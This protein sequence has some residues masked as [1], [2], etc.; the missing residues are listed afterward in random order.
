MLCPPEVGHYFVDNDGTYVPKTSN[1]RMICKR[2]LKEL[3]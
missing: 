1:A 2:C 3:K